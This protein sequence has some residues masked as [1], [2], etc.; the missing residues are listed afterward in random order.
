MSYTEVIEKIHSL[1]TG[2]C[3]SYG[4]AAQAD[5]GEDSTAAVAAVHDSTADTKALAEFVSLCSCVAF[6]PVHLNGVT[7]DL[8]EN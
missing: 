7:E 5:S 6:S 8:W 2:S 3:M 1:G 4:I